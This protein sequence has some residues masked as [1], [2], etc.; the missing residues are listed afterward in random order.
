MGT[1]DGLAEPDEPN[2]PSEEVR[3]VITIPEE[4]TG[5]S[6]HE[7]VAREGLIADM[8]TQGQSVTIHASLPAS[9]YNALAEAIMMNTLGRG[10]SN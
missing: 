2:P 1:L 4:F 8:T 6:L 10:E 7:L 3:V 9:N 5:V